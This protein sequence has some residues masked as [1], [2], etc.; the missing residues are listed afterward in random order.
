MKIQKGRVR[1]RTIISCAIALLCIAG[2]GYSGFKIIEWKIDSNKTAAQ[3][4]QINELTK[5]NEVEDDD[6]TEVI[7]SDEGEESLYRKFIKMS[8]IDVDY[9]ELRKINNEVAGWV[10]VKGTNINYPFVSNGNNDYYLTHSFDK[11]Y[12]RAG[13]VFS[14]FRN[15][16]DGTDKNTILYAHGR[17]D[18]TMFGTLRNILSS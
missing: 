5:I 16:L 17:Y 6:N 15:K 13:W 9:S 18:E 8:L 4:E 12:S 14:D 7:A 11:S 2:I 10:Q 1:A 3:T